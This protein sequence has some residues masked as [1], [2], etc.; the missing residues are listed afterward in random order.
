[1][2]FKED[3]TLF[4][5]IKGEHLLVVQIYVDDIIFG[6]T[7]KYLCED[8]VGLMSSE[9]EMSMM[10]EL[11]FYPG[12]QIKQMKERTMIHQQKYLREM[13]KKFGIESSKTYDT[14]IPTS[15]KLDSDEKDKKLD[16]K[17]YRGYYVDRKSTSGM[18]HFLG[19]CLVSW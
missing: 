6:A 11:N 15:A 16:E 10:G 4:L 2:I 3:K 18:A 13:L 12:L 19:P 1:M 5:R 14:L 8:F 9:F 17:L 7:N